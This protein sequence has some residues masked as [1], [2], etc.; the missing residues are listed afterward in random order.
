MSIDDQKALECDGYNAI[1]FLKKSHFIIGE[2]VTRVVLQF[3]DSSD[4]YK[5]INCIKITLIP[6]VPNTSKVPKFISISY[7]IILYKLIAKGAY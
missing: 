7:C 5:L 1:F 3:F 4:M 2:D 6:K